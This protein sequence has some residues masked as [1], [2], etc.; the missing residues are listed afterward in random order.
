MH[1]AGADEVFTLG[2][3]QAVDAIVDGTETI[4]KST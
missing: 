2:G 1:L 3:V 4:S